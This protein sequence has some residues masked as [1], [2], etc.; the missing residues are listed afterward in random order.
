MFIHVGIW[1]QAGVACARFQTIILTRGWCCSAPTAQGLLLVA[2]PRWCC[3]LTRRN[4]PG[5]ATFVLV[6]SVL[7]ARSGL[8]KRGCQSTTTDCQPHSGY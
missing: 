2:C 4:L 8:P 5:T 6:D 3:V 1:A 7:V